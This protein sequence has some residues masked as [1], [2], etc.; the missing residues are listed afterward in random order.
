MATEGSAGGTPEGWRAKEVLGAL[1]QGSHA[2]L[3]R[4]VRQHLADTLAKSERAESG[5]AMKFKKARS[6]SPKRERE[7]AE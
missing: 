1:P 4:S 6:R 7:A 5:P 3:C 2:L